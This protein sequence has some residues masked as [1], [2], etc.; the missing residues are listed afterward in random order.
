MNFLFKI[1][2]LFTLL[3][4]V[5]SISNIHSM[6]YDSNDNIN[7]YSY[8][9]HHANNNN[10]PIDWYIL[11]FVDE[12]D[13]ADELAGAEQGVL[14]LHQ[15]YRSMLVPHS[16]M[17]ENNYYYIRMNISKNGLATDSSMNQ[18]QIDRYKILNKIQSQNNTVAS[19]Q[20]M[21]YY[22]SLLH[23][24]INSACQLKDDIKNGLYCNDIDPNLNEHGLLSYNAV[25][26]TLQR[27]CRVIINKMLL[28]VS[29][30]NQQR[31]LLDFQADFGIFTELNNKQ[32]NDMYVK[33]SNAIK[34][35]N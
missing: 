35:K 8:N 28:L 30:I 27:I 11:E 18:W 29:N 31:D 20:P 26:D 12:P 7:T 24:L 33:L 5:T 17:T 34:P 4:S 16:K 1:L 6:E 14:R 23:I 3:I 15:S 32:L 13:W 25:C 2:P 10:V 9:D 21:D 22:L 19:N